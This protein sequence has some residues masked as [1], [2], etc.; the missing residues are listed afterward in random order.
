ME[1]H[2]LKQ[3]ILQQHSGV[4]VEN[5][6]QRDLFEELPKLPGVVILSGIRRCGKSTVLQQLR[7]H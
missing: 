5:Y 2:V 1:L 4:K 7:K 6:M 3:I